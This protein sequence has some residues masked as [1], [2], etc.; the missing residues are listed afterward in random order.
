MLAQPVTVTSLLGGG[1]GEPATV[2]EHA[3]LLDDAPVGE[4]PGPRRRRRPRW[5]AVEQQLDVGVLEQTL[6]LGNALDIG[7]GVVVED[8][9]EAALARGLARMLHPFDQRP[10]ARVVE[11]Q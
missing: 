8:R 2:L 10:P 11:P 7:R 3:V 5:A 1:R 9:V 6:D 4:R